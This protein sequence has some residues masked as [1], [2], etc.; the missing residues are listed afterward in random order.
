[1]RFLFDIG[2]PAEVHTFKH[3]IRNLKA[4]G[5]EV[6]V[7]AR[8]KEMTLYLLDQYQIPYVS[9]G[10]NL[11]SKAGKAWAFLR[12]DLKIFKTALKFKPD[13]VINFFSP[14]AAHAGNSWGKR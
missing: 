8:D 5:H 11:G 10:R 14:F 12:N 7:T 9:T 2:H 1:M 4:N 13:L 6:L 3:V